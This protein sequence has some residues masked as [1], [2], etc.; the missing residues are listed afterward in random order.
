MTGKAKDRFGITATGPE[1]G[2]IT[3]L[4]CLAL[5]TQRGQAVGQDLLATRVIG[6][7]RWA[8]DECS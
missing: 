4:H 2:H 3:E 8:L 7:H 5:E 6:R 1:I